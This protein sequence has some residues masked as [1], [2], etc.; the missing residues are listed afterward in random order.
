MENQKDNDLFFVCNL[1]EYISRKT[2]NYKNY[3]IEKI[4]KENIEKIYNL[5]EIY[6][7]ENIEKVSDEI[8]QK[9]NI[10]NGDYDILSNTTNSVPPTYW[11]MGKVYH[12]LIIS[13]SKNEQ[14]YIEKLCEFF[15]SWMIKKFDNYNSSLY[16]ENPS[17]LLACYKEGRII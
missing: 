3:I 17:Y 12:R 16:F 15:N 2:N 11:D 14:E 9:Y 10:L 13:I 5:A 1:I 8:I 7:S 4:G 6:H